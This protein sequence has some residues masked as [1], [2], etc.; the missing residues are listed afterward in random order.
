MAA[1]ESDID[2]ALFERM[3]LGLVF[4]IVAALEA[5]GGPEHLLVAGF[6]AG[7]ARFSAASVERSADVNRSISRSIS[8]RSATFALLC[9]RSA[10]LWRAPETLS[11]LF[12]FS[13]VGAGAAT[14]YIAGVVALTARSRMAL[15]AALFLL[16]FLFSLLI[17][18]GS[19]PVD[20][21]GG[22]LLLRP[23]RSGGVQQDRR[24]H[25]G[26]VSAQR[27]DRRRRAARARSLSAATMAPAEHSARSRPSSPR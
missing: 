23:R 19:P 8:S 2:G 17:A 20:Q 22:A 13:P 24:A 10:V 3:L 6:F 9:D 18:L 21:I 25:A 1:S 11:E 5:S 4:A 14:L 26:P 15:R 12:R 27:G 16:P 7:G